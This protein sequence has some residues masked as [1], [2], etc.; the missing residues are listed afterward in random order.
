MLHVSSCTFVLLQHINRKTNSLVKVQMAL[1]QTAGCPRANH[2]K[3]FMCSPRNT[4]NINSSLW[5]TGGLSQGCSDFQK[6]HVF[7]VSVPFSCP[8]CACLS[9]LQ[10]YGGVAEPPPPPGYLRV[11]WGSST[12]RGGGQKVRHVFRNPGR[13]DGIS[14]DFCQ[15][16]LGGARKVWEKNVCSILIP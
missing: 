4:A 1:R 9:L 7:K 11:G 6:A 5:L 12:W 15:D 13:P 3:K 16:V 10:V 8:N 14:W 2:A